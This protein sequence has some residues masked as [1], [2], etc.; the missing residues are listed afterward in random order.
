MEAICKVCKRKASE[1]LEYNLE[2]DFYN[3]SPDEFVKNEIFGDG[4]YNKKDNTFICTECYIK[5]GCP[6]ND[7]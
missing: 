3:I 5:L 4:T 1:I 6:T 7:F 2:A